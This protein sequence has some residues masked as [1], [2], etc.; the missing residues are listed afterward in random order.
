M[1]IAQFSTIYFLGIGGI[2]MS[3]LARYFL[4]QGKEVLGYDRTQTPLTDALAQAGAHIHF[5][6]DISHTQELD[7]KSTL[8]IITPAI[9]KGHQEWNYLHENNFTI[10]KR[11][12]ALGLISEGKYTYA[13]AGT[14]GK[15]TTS[16]MLAHLLKACSEDVNAF[17]GG[18]SSNY[19][20]NMLLGEKETVVLEA[21]EFDRSFMQ[22]KPN[23]SI[24]TSTD[25]DHLD[26]YGD[27]STIKEGF[28]DFMRLTP[29]SGYLIVHHG[30]DYPKEI[31]NVYTY[32]LDPEADLFAYNIRVDNG[33]YIFDLG[34]KIELKDCVLGMA[35]IHNVENA[36]AACLACVLN[37]VS[38]DN[39]KSGLQTFIGVKRRFEYCIRKENLVYIDDYAHHPTE[40]EQCIKSV[41][42]LFPGKRVTGAFQPH[43]Y[44]RT[45]DFVDGFAQSLSLLDELI[46]LDIYPAREEPI[47]GVSSA[48]L[49]E[50]VSI[51]DKKLLAKNEL[52][53]YVQAK[54]PEVFLTMGAGDIDQLVEP[55]KKA[56]A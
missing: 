23:T 33:Q 41:R 36:V 2:G 19:N 8:V 51:A 1:D 11:A 20:S 56:L 22:I 15:T 54:R 7:S 52:V 31:K 26:I 40:L 48:W 3:A 28:K 27:E 24:V 16:T 55:I 37:E 30:L 29:D 45:R 34:G 17:L 38:L 13:V 35:G 32:G 12:K 43:L 10:I 4:H 49:L 39:L 44:S 18:I 25:A 47:E 21:D 5:N 14:H 9:P 46:L 50:K 42:Q 53:N 6:D